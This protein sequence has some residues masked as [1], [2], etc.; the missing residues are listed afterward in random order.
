L[1]KSQGI[2]RLGEPDPRGWQVLIKE[3]NPSEPSKRCREVADPQSKATKYGTGLKVVFYS[4][5]YG[6]N[7][8]TFRMA[9]VIQMA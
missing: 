1:V 5:K 2:E 8:F 6:G 7:L 9:G 3:M 4:T